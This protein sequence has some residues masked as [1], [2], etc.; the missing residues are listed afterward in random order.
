MTYSRL[1]TVMKYGHLTTG[2]PP[3]WCELRLSR[4]TL[5]RAVYL[6][7]IWASNSAFVAAG[8]IGVEIADRIAVLI[9]ALV[10][11]VVPVPRPSGVRKNRSK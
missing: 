6:A 7:N 4:A 11:L 5:P 2:V 1:C 3:L 10:A 9:K 8:A